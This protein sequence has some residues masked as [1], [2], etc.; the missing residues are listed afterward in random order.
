Q[1]TK[2]PGRKLDPLK[3]KETFKVKCDVHPWMTAWIR[4][5]DH[6]FF[7]T[8]KEDGTFEIKDLPDGQYT[9]TAWHEKYG[10]KE[11]KI[12]VRDGKAQ[13][14]F[15]FNANAN[16]GAAVPAPRSVTLANLT[17]GDATGPAAGC[18]AVKTKDTGKPSC[19]GG[20]KAVT[21]AAPVAPAAQAE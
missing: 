20:D 17:S 13:A 4:A 16:G 9:L 1:P 3:A 8:T 2:E 15:A 18:C 7:A 11:Q 6:P 19:C 12:E 10:E 5:F 21:N 14:N